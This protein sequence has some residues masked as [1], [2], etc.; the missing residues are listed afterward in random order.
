[1][2]E[3]RTTDEQL[4]D[5]LRHRPVGTTAAQM[6][7]AADRLEMLRA[8]LIGAIEVIQTW[9]NMGLAGKHASEMWDIYWRNAPEM[10]PIREALSHG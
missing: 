1:M 7:E 10:K 2:T 9:H 6:R 8:A 5:C 4:I 3:Q